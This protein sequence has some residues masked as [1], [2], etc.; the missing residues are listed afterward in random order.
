MILYSLSFALNDPDICAEILNSD[1]D[2]IKNWAK[3]RNKRGPRTEPCGT[4]AG[5]HINSDFWPLTTT[6]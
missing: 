6:D 1:L 5:M 2:K 4:P 3:I